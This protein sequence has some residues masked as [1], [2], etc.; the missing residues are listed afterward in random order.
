M[1][2]IVKEIKNINTYSKKMLEIIVK[3]IKI[4]INVT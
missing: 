4:K 3:F 2:Y 1:A